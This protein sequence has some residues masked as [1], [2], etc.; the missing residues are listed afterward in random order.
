MEAVLNVGGLAYCK[1]EIEDAPMP[2][3]FNLIDHII[4][5]EGVGIAIP[6]LTLFMFDQTG[7]LQNELNL[8]QGTKCIISLAKNGQKDRIVKRTFSLWGIRRGVSNA[9]PQVQA[10][11]IQDIPKWSAGVYCENY[12]STSDECMQRIASSAGLRYDGPGGTDDKM[13]WLNVNTTRSSF[14]EDVAMR[15]YAGSSSCM[16]RAVTLDNDMR[17]KDLFQ[18]MKEQELFTFIL[19]GSDEGMTNP[20]AVRET[21]ESSMSGAMAHWFNYGQIQYEHSLDQKGQQTTDRIMAPVLGDAFPISERVKG[22]ISDAMAARVTYTG[23]DPGTEPNEA[24]NVHEYY[25]RAFYQNLRG[26]GLFSERIQVLV[27]DLTD[28]KTFDPC[29][30]H[31][32]DP[33]GHQM[34][35]SRSLNGKYLIAG[36]TMRIKNGHAYV[37]VLDLVRPYIANPGKSEQ[38]SGT[39][40][41][42]QASANEGAFDLSSGREQQLT[43]AVQNQE[44]PTPTDSA[45]P[46]VQQ[47]TELM[48]SLEKYDEA[49]PDIPAEPLKSP[50]AMSPS[51]KQAI[52]QDE[53]RKAVA[54]V[55]KS[56]GPLAQSLE[57]SRAGFDPESN[58]TVKRVSAAAV[59]TSAN[60]TIDSMQ[61]YK[62]ETGSPISGPEGL[63]A[64]AKAN[65]GV[66]LEKPV[67]DRFSASG[68]EIK[69]KQFESA[70]TPVSAEKVEEGDFLG[71]LQKGGVFVEDFLKNGQ[72]DPTEYLGMKGVDAIEQEDNKGTNFV[73]PASSFGLGADDV[74]IGPKQVAEFLL[75]Y[76]KERENPDKFMREKGVAAYRASFGDVP[77]DTAG[78]QIKELHRVASSVSQKFGD[79][80][81][82]AEPK[83]TKAVETSAAVVDRDTKA[84]KAK[85]AYDELMQRNPNATVR[86]SASGLDLKTSFDASG[87]QRAANA[88]AR[89]SNPD[90]AQAFDFQFG[91]S[92]VSPLLERVSEKGRNQEYTDV[93]I[94]KTSREAV[95][96]A[97]YTR[98][99][100]DKAKKTGQEEDGVHWEFP[101][102]VPFDQYDEGEG[103]AH[104]FTDKPSSF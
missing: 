104:D 49:N 98:I 24:S 31:Q 81:V 4:M 36:K 29:K 65:T 97:Q 63:P 37:E 46:E 38:A 103:V 12:R 74:T 23:F 8:V 26:L 32:S 92:G 66:K 47:A 2:R 54:E 3:S 95:S 72:D 85:A 56:E 75:D 101:H 68:N 80:E 42:Q 7:T 35:P 34:T 79:S 43:T 53:V 25:E 41:N 90:Y 52:A 100:S 83:L 13:N 50:G 45:K 77:P 99:G 15:G 55:Q 60:Q 39:Q 57:Q 69:N 33:V 18:Q 64:S 96:W 14:S 88:K 40:G 78:E 30:Y 73:F 91:Q 94:I 70:V 62:Q 1:L 27:D 19:N 93:E 16:A 5:Q 86:S 58:H 28:A 61:T 59:K 71:D 44:T 17:Y 89:G 48:Q 87:A 82:L 21:E 10:V 22:L 6:T 76:A 11:F 67:L 102:A 84:D 51:D 20:F 9:G